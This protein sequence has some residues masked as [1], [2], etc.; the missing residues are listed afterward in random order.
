MFH[1]C[2]G[3][4]TKII[5]TGDNIDDIMT[6]WWVG[7]NDDCYK[8]PHSKSY[9]VIITSRYIS[10]LVFTFNIVF[11]HARFFLFFIIFFDIWFISS[12][13][14]S[15]LWLT[16][17]NEEEFSYVIRAVSSS[18]CTFHVRDETLMHKGPKVVWG[19]GREGGGREL[20]HYLAVGWSVAEEVGRSVLS[21]V[22]QR[23]TSLSHLSHSGQTLL[24]RNYP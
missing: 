15:S 17:G 22:R 11:S 16:K 19:R 18:Y 13:D 7:L 5:W 4:L 21:C 12:S 20:R 9:H 24:L 3:S 2:Q 23:Q 14:T 6:T 1:Y 8:L 10:I